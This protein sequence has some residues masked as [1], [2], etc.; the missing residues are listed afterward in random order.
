MPSKKFTDKNP[1]KQVKPS[2][3]YKDIALSNIEHHGEEWLNF[4]QEKARNRTD[5]EL[6]I[7][8][9]EDGLMREQNSFPDGDTRR[10]YNAGDETSRAIQDK[11]TYLDPITKRI[12]GI[13][14]SNAGGL[15]H[16][17]KNI[18]D[19]RPWMESVEDATNNFA[20]SLSSI[21]S[22]GTSKN[23]FNKYYRKI[24]PDGKVAD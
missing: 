17:A 20:G 7:K 23:L 5:E 19:G 14:G 11:L 13:L 18:K 1:F 9:D 22:R 4:P 2:E 10:H 8:P 6:N 3:K 15:I 21:F 24:A 16:E 12:V